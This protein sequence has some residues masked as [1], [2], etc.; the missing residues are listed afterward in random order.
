MLLKRNLKNKYCDLLIILVLI[1]FTAL[2][3]FTKVLVWSLFI[4]TNPPQV[5]LLKNTWQYIERRNAGF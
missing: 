5:A 4:F 3:F 1:N 2:F